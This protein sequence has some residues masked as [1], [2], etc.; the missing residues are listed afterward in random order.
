[1]ERASSESQIAECA[2]DRHPWPTVASLLRQALLS[3]GQAAPTAV[4]NLCMSNRTVAL[5]PLRGGSKSIPRK[6]IKPI[7]GMPLCAWVLEA[8]VAVKSISAVFV[9]TDDDEIASVVERLGLG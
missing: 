1:G 7:A 6:N 9:S 3:P 5:V 8:T 4:E 2:P